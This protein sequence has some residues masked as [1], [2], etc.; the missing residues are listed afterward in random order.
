MHHG[1]RK[2]LKFW[3][4]V[5]QQPLRGHIGKK[6]TSFLNSLIQ[7]T[8]ISIYPHHDKR[9]DF[10]FC[11]LIIG[12][13]VALER[14]D[15]KNYFILEFLDSKTYISICIM[16]SDKRSEAIGWPQR[17]HISKKMSFFNSLTPKTYISIYIMVKGWNSIFDL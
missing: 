5:I 13:W 11:P 16:T 8:F 7:K 1:K 2:N 3:S 10:N 12:H 17:G 9:M 15:Q 6:L 4:E 14:S